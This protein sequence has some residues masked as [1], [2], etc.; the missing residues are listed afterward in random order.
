MTKPNIVRGIDHIGI[1]VPNVNDAAQFLEK[2]FQANTLYD[3][4]E[5]ED[6]PME[7]EETEQQLG[8]PKGSKIVH[9][10]LMKIGESATIELFEFVN[11]KQAQA[12]SLNDFG[13]T[14]FALYVDD[15]EKAAERFE[16]AG[17]KLLS[18]IHSLGG[19]E[20][21]ANN[22]GVYGKA[23]WGSLIELI[24]YP[25]GLKKESIDRWTPPKRK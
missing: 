5:K 25:D 2:A 22:A 17:G 24:T 12:F 1:T 14:H 8:I 21:G 10:K 11:V 9:M 6:E 3:L 13:Y 7:G 4:I 18:E 20:D 23:P 15:I 19:I 16:K